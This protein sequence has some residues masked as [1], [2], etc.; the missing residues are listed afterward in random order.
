MKLL[1]PFLLLGTMCFGQSKTSSPEA[2]YI[3]VAKS[4]IYYESRGSGKPV[5]L[6]HAG[7]L[8]HGMWRQQVRAL[9]TQFQVVTIDLP[10]HGAT[11]YTDSTLVIADVIKIVLDSLHL[12]KASIVGLS[13]GSLAAQDFV[14]AYPARVDKAVFLSPG[15]NGW[16][17]RFPADTVTK[18]FVTEFYQTLANHDS[19]ATAEVFAHY[20]G[21]GLGRDK[22]W[23]PRVRQYIYATTYRSIVHHRATTWPLFS[24]SPFA[25]D[26]VSGI[27]CPVLII[28]GANDLPSVLSASRYLESVIPG[29]KAMRIPGVA[30]MLNLEQPEAINKILMGFLR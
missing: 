11:M 23:N 15:I 29:A 2:G 8:D 24:E 4:R 21:D 18:R 7:L 10:G 22:S 13:M 30:H 9:Q 20:W 27:R 14:I 28:Y 19:A 5:L 16:E 12:P 17:R 26:A 6:L 1:L 25:I 3:R